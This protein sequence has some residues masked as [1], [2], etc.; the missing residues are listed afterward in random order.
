[1]LEAMEATL[2]LGSPSNSMLLHVRGEANLSHESA[3]YMTTMQRW[4]T[5]TTRYCVEI[6]PASHEP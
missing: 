3:V 4:V 1:M 2:T 5:I 6:Y